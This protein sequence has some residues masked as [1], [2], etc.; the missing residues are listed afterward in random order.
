[1]LRYPTD[2]LWQEVAYL[3]YHLHWTLDDLLDLEH[4]DRVR[5]IRAVSALNDRAWEAAREQL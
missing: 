4:L 1:M 2:A 3:S 5:L